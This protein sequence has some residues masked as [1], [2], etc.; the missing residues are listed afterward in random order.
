MAAAFLSLSYFFSMRV[1]VFDL[2]RRLSGEGHPGLSTRHS[3]SFHTSGFVELSDQRQ[4][5]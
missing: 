2:S 3:A 1:S 5:E 4:R